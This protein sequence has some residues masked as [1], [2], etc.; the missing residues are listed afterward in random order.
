MNARTR[1]KIND[2]P[3]EAEID[4]PLITKYRPRVFK[5]VLSQDATVASLE[6]ALASKSRPHAFLFTG[7]S[8]VGKT[9]LA[10]IVAFEVDV[11]DSSVVELDAASHSG[12]DDVRALLAPLRFKGFGE[13]PNKMIIVD[14]IHRLSKQAFDVLLKTLEE[15]PPHVFFALCTTEPGKVPEAIR[16]RCA[17]YS[18]KPGKRD[19]LIDLL[20]AVCKAEDFDTPSKFLAMIADAAKGS[21]RLALSMLSVAHACT[22][23]CE[24]EDLLEYAGES[25]EV[26]ELCRALVSRKLTFGKAIGILKALPDQNGENIRLIIV[27]Y[28]NACLLGSKTDDQSK[29]LL[30]MLYEFRQPCMASEKLAPILLALGNLLL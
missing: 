30:D 24:V 8:G 1:V 15:P 3:Q 2:A 6:K 7:P 5:N 10:R 16:T 12:A 21:H 19:D 4:N 25:A 11:P 29:A 28:L 27:N 17:S 26:I 22:N 18:L 23:E 20:E 14:E 9:T 13:R